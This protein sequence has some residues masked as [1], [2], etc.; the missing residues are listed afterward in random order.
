MPVIGG[1]FIAAGIGMVAL[2]VANWVSYRSAIASAPEWIYRLE[3]VSQSATTPRA[4][5]ADARPAL[6]LAW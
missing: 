1:I 4:S 2:V 3:G 6:T 5:V